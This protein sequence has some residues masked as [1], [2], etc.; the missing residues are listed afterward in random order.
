MTKQIKQVATTEEYIVV[1]YEDDSIGVYNRY[2]NAK[3]ALREIAIEHGFEYDPSWTTRQFGK[4][5]I[6]GV[7]NGAPA[8]ADNDYIV[9]IDANGTVIC[10]R[11]TEGSAK[12]ALRMIA[13]KYSI[14]YEE[15]WNTQQ[16]GR[17]VI[18][19]L[20]SFKA[21]TA[22]KEEFLEKIRKDIKEFLD[23]NSKLF[24]NE[25]DFQVNLS[26][27][28]KEQHY[29]DYVFLEY[30]LPEHIGFVGEEET[31]ESEAD[32]DSNIR[33]D[34]VVEKG[35]KYIPIE[36]KYKTKSTEGDTIVR[37]GKLI[38]AK[39]LKDQLAQNINRY[40][41]W[42]DVE[43][44]ETIKKHFQP[45]VVAGF[46]IFMTNDE[47]YTKTP[48]GASASF[49]ME[50]ENQRP[51]ELNWEGEVA[52]STIDKYPTISLEREYTIEKWDKKTTQEIDFHYCIVEI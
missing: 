48:K 50:A 41:F 46:C 37:F 30:S 26:S 47:N 19:H 28:L 38:K 14:T 52:P 33:I 42:K 8:I 24:F 39:L 17:K 29:Y 11:K 7:G 45:N 4:K 10:G 49:T 25:R 18:E 22:T 34:I 43:R 21:S 27:F 1:R 31:L 6:D 15:G 12:G 2:G 32:L 51:K 3:A 35:G 16:F 40:L 13:E 20:L 9:Y 36:L 5:M 44:I 23:K